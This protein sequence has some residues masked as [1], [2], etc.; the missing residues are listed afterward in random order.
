VWG[1][2]EEVGRRTVA[3]K[4]RK[5]GARAEKFTITHKS[6]VETEALHRV[7]VMLQCTA[8]LF[9]TQTLLDCS[10][11]SMLMH[12]VEPL[13]KFHRPPCVWQQHR[14]HSVTGSHTTSSCQPSPWPSGPSCLCQLMVRCSHDVGAQTRWAGRMCGVDARRGGLKHKQQR[15]QRQEG[16]CAFFS[17]WARNALEN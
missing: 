16:K 7:H 13:R 11:H 8:R 10:E 1:K 15:R 4:G 9:E 12:T 6:S 14:M 5:Q 17:R 3:G 2:R